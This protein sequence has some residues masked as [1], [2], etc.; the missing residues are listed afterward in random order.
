L[1]AVARRSDRSAKARWLGQKV[2]NAGV[3][4][5]IIGNLGLI[6]SIIYLDWICSVVGFAIGPDSDFNLHLTLSNKLQKILGI[7]S[8]MGLFFLLFESMNFL[9][10]IFKQEKGLQGFTNF[11]FVLRKEDCALLE[12]LY[13]AGV[14]FRG[15]ASLRLRRMA[16][17]T[18][19]EVMR[20][21]TG[22]PLFIALGF[23]INV[24][25]FPVKFLMFLAFYIIFTVLF[26]PVRASCMDSNT[27]ASVLKIF[28]RRTLLTFWQ[29]AK[30]LS[31]YLINI[32]FIYM[33][34]IMIL[35]IIDLLF[36]LYNYRYYEI[37]LDWHPT[38]VAWALAIVTLSQ[39]RRIEVF[40]LAGNPKLQREALRRGEVAFREWI[41]RNAELPDPRRGA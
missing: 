8:L 31:K 22:W 5:G 10:P 1:A 34:F 2:L 25:F 18:E 17:L 21:R 33:L 26:L 20:W 23:V 11:L 35:Y 16:V 19:D 29:D 12:E 9:K 24:H 15:I 39:R 32:L 3:F 7:F 14:G 13:L 38:I 36:Y 37:L 41:Q 6:A 4:V 28:E 27:L 40:C 30:I